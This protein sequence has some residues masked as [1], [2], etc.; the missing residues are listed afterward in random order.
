MESGLIY[1]CSWNFERRVSWRMLNPDNYEIP[2]LIRLARSV[3]AKRHDDID[4]PSGVW[5]IDT[6]GGRAAL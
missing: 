3:K 6:P 4:W 1:D 5:S 2:K